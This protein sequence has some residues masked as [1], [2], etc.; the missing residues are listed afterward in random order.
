MGY[1]L[2]C[3]CQEKASYHYARMQFQGT[4]TL[5]RHKYVRYILVN[6]KNILH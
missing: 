2:Q 5:Q 3:E 4:A 6:R 1:L